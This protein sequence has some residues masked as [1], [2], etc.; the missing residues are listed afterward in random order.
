MKDFS[1]EKPKC[2]KGVVIERLGWLV[3]VSVRKRHEK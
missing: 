3:P 1:P 2:L